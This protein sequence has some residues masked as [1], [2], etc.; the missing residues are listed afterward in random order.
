MVILLLIQFLTKLILWN[1]KYVLLVLYYND[2]LP[3]LALEL[4]IDEDHVIIYFFFIAL[5]NFVAFYCWGENSPPN[6]EVEAMKLLDDHVRINPGYGT[7]FG[8]QDFFLQPQE[9]QMQNMSFYGGNPQQAMYA[10]PSNFIA[11][12][13]AGYMVRI[14][15]K[16]WFL[17]LIQ[18]WWK[19]VTL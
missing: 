10:P 5:A 18:F 17:F 15:N 13:S 1:V 8:S 6:N 16:V 4:W 2:F 7:S 12:P 3:W 9:M 14:V 19:L 11:T